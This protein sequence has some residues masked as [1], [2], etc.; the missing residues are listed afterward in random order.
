MSNG[1][2]N[3]YA[4]R[5]EK[6]NPIKVRSITIMGREFKFNEFDYVLAE[7][8]WKRLKKT[9]WDKRAGSDMKEFTAPLLMQIEFLFKTMKETVKQEGGIQ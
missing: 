6:K 4:K 1:I 5:R 8:L 2:L 7:R 9:H 3:R